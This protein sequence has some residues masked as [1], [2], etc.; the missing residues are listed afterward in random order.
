MVLDIVIENQWLN[1]C[2]FL[3]HHVLNLRHM[4]EQQVCNKQEVQT[5]YLKL[6]VSNGKDI[7][8]S[9]L[10]MFVCPKEL[11]TL[12]TRLTTKF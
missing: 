11:G 10:L 4:K 6:F 1:Y 9:I 2:S 3:L 12:H 8:E 7:K 5:E